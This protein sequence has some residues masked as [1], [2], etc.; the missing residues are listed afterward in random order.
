[1]MNSKAKILGQVRSL[2]IAAGAFAVGRGYFD[3]VAMMEIVGGLVAVFG[4]AWSWFD[5]AKNV[6]KGD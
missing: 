4:A 2:L 6:G 3:E 5:P 1:M